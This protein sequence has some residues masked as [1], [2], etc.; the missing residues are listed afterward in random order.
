MNIGNEEF[1]LH[2]I[3]F[4]SHCFPSPRGLGFK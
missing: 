3:E 1:I 2:C 4:H